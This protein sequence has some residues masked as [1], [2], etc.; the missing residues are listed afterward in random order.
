MN[1]HLLAGMNTISR[2]I[3]GYELREV[4]VESLEYQELLRLRFNEL[5]KP[6]GLEWT[7]AEG[8]ADKKDR[9]FGLYHEEVLVGSVVVATLTPSFAKLRQ[10]AVVKSQQGQGVGQS[11]MAA[12]ENFLA[13]DGVKRFEL[14][15]RV[16]V[17]GF[18]DSLNYRRQGDFFEEIGLPHVK[19]I[20][21][22][23]GNESA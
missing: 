22:L 15:A 23:R 3:E 21:L 11:L 7:E 18:Y 20:K 16:D 9:H 10:I 5:R 1:A 19:M 4:Y 6:L 12:I 8:E 14:N 17:A 13:R 2:D